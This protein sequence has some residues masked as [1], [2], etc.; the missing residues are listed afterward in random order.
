MKPDH[1]TSDMSSTPLV[2][3]SHSSKTRPWLRTR[4]R[5]FTFSIMLFLA[6]MVVS[7]LLVM[8][9]VAIW[10]ND[11]PVITVPAGT[12]QADSVLVQVKPTFITEVV[13]KKIQEAGLPGTV[14]HVQVDLSHNDLLIVTGD[15]TITLLVFPITKHFTIT[16]QPYISNCQVQ[17]RIVHASFAGIPV[18]G[19]VTRFDTLINQQLR[20]N[21][22]NL[23]Q[24]FTY[25]ATSIRT[26]TQGLFVTLSI[27]AV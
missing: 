17:M 5:R 26:E 20:I 18:T 2:D 4:A 11:R 27:K 1:K 9:S 22:E 10:G 16:L 6:G 8:L 25:C 7:L 12:P 15:D 21:A 19:F 14:S 13:Q 23:P 3:G 24:G